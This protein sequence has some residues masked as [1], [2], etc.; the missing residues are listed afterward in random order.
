MMMIQMSSRPDAGF[1]IIQQYFDILWCAREVHVQA[2]QFRMM[3]DFAHALITASRLHWHG[4]ICQPY[5]AA[6]RHSSRSLP[7]P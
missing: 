6:R 1:A 3:E 4:A 7:Q 5:D 2:G